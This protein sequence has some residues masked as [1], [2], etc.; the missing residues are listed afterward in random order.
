PGAT[1]VAGPPS[2]PRPDDARESAVGRR[3]DTWGEI[4]AY[5]KRDVATV[6]RW[7]KSEGLPVRRHHHNKQGSVYAYTSEIDR[8]LEARSQQVA[9]NQP[10]VS[11]LATAARIYPRPWVTGRSAWLVAIAAMLV[12]AFI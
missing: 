10:V 4:A 1:S 12:R 9:E 7:E 11:G 8:W 2:D 6:R 3:L 5:A